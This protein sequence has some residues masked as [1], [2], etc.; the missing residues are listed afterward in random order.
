MLLLRA[1]MLRN[2]GEA[3]SFGQQAIKSRS[4]PSPAACGCCCCPDAVT[5]SVR[6]CVALKQLLILAVYIV[7]D[8]MHDDWSVGSTPC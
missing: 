3:P 8:G 4:M 7:R 1:L 6:Q 5:Y 2:L